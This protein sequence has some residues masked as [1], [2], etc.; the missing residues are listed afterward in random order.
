MLEELAFTIEKQGRG[1]CV[2]V[3][4]GRW[5]D[6][7]RVGCMDVIVYVRHLNYMLQDVSISTC[8]YIHNKKAMCV[9]HDFSQ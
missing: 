5:G 2:F 6:N 8:L 3:P 4:Y 9:P 7:S 1:M